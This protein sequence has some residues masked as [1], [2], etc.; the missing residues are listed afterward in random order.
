MQ[1]RFSPAQLADPALAEAESILRKCVHCGFCTATC[2]TYVLLGDENDSPRGRIYLIKD[3]LEGDKPASPQVTRHVDRCLSCLSC[4]TTCPSGVD[5]MHLVDQARDRIAATAKRPLADRLL[6]RLLARVL[7]DPRLF[8]LSIKAARLGRLMPGGLGRLAASA[9]AS[10]PP[11]PALA[12]GTYPAEGRRRARVALLAGCV[13]QV[14]G[15]DVN[16]ATVRLLNR[17]GVEVAVSPD[18]GCCGALVHHLGDRAAAEQAARR[19]VAAW[20][21][22]GELDAVVVNASGC[23]TV[24][25]DYGHLLGGDRDAARI[26][27]LTKD[28]SEVLADLKFAAPAPPEEARATVVVYHAACSLQHGQRVRLQPKAL[29][30]AAGFRVEEPADSHLCCGSAGSYSITQ[31]D[32]SRQLR[33]RKVATLEATGGRVIASGNVGCIEHL[34][35]GTRLPVVHTVQLLDWASGGPR[36]RGL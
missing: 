8:R 10:L 30:G 15:T 32:L 27:A 20:S 13:Q 4:M 34:R 28:V 19:N 3:M 2:P 23:G 9:P 21:A 17:L 24:V 18:A 29:L 25:K 26:A 14:L 1:T 35:A 11:E 22:L 31:P 12:P 7:P 36:P 33:D 6:R 5:Y 16:A